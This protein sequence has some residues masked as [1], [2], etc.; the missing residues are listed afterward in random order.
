MTTQ[1]NN[2]STEQIL[3]GA[4]TSAKI[5]DG[6]IVD[7]DMSI[8]PTSKTTGTYTGDGTDN[9]GI[10]HGH[11]EAPTVI[12]IFRDSG[13]TAWIWN[14]G[15]GGW[16][17]VSAGND[18]Q[19]TAPDATNFYVSSGTTNPNQDTKEFSWIAIT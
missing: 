18:D 13:G 19:D 2:V 16:V 9:R 4:V 1:G 17:G 12:L 11:D 10:A 5:K 3:D 15:W 8:T 6:T 14:T 7:S